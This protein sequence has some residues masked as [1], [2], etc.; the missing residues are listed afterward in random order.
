M[1]AARRSLNEYRKRRDRKDPF[2]YLTKK[3]GSP[4]HDF[5]G[6]PNHN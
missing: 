5:T 3:A 1:R 6:S 4:N 2:D